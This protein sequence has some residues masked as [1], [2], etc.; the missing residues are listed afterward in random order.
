MRAMRLDCVPDRN[1]RIVV[2]PKPVIRLLHLS[3]AR[4]ILFADCNARHL[5]LSSLREAS[6]VAASTRGVSSAGIPP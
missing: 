3:A 2:E 5:T 6:S 4:P 1:D